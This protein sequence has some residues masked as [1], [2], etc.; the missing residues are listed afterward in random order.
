MNPKFTFKKTLLNADAYNKTSSLS[1]YNTRCPFNR[2]NVLKEIDDFRKQ[3]HVNNGNV[4][5]FRFIDLS[6]Y[7]SDCF[8]FVFVY[9]SFKLL[10]SASLIFFSYSYSDFT[11]RSL[12]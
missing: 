12:I 3:F 5:I 8:V 10:V 2:F 4:S 7:L 6:V 1:N 11:I 9:L